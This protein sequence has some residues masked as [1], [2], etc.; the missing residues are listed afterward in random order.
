MGARARE[1][2]V[3]RISAR[4]R[5]RGILPA[6]DLQVGDEII[7]RNPEGGEVV[8]IVVPQRC[9]NTCRMAFHKHAPFT[10]IDWPRAKI[11]HRFLV[12]A[13]RENTS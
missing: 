13:P 7:L 8:T 3:A 5:R 10:C 11:F 1:A 6:S 4:S 2:V 12:H 9:K